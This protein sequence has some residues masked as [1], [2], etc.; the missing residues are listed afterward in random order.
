MDLPNAQIERLLIDPNVGIVSVTMTPAPGEPS[1]SERSWEVC[2]EAQGELNRLSLAFEAPAGTATTDLYWDG[3]TSTP[4][5]QL[6]RTCSGFLPQYSQIAP[7]C[8]ATCGTYSEGPDFMDPVSTLYVVLTGLDPSSEPPLTKLNTANG[9]TCVG[10]V[11]LDDPGVPPDLSINGLEGLVTQPPIAAAV[12]S[13]APF[14]VPDE[15]STTDVALT[16]AGAGSE[17]TDNDSVRDE[18]DNCEFLANTS[19]T[20]TGGLLST[21]G[22]D[23]V[24]DDCQCGD[25]DFD[26][27]MLAGGA[28][29]DLLVDVLLGTNTSPAVRNRAS[30][31][32][33]ATPGIRDAVFLQRALDGN[34]PGITQACEDG[35][36][37]VP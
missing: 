8:G 35:V 16:A 29:L 17:D 19:Q 5:A 9:S 36:L 33:G 7:S 27:R 23:G 24:G 34:D 32:D 10:R 14:G 6:R 18:D 22:N 11:F 20:N 12:D 26:G 13:V 30:V 31:V 28:D 25:L 2:V 21:F 4:D 37:P 15:V 3:C 1:G